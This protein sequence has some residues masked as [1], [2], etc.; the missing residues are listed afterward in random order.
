MQSVFLEITKP[1]LALFIKYEFWFHYLN[2]LEKRSIP[3]YLVSG[4]FRT[5]QHFFKGY[6]GWFKGM[7]NKFEHL[8]VQ[9]ESSLKLLESIGVSNASIS[10]DTRFDSVYAIAQSEGEVPFIEGFK[11]ESQLLICGSTWPEDEKLVLPLINKNHHKLKYIIAPHDVSDHRI[12]EL[13]EKIQL[14]TVRYSAMDETTANSAKV[15]IIDSIGLLAQ[16]YRYG[17][18]AYVGG[19]FGSGLHNILEPAA[20]AMPVLYGTPDSKFYEAYELAKKG[21]GFFVSNADELKKRIDFLLRDELILKM[22][23][24]VSRNYVIESKG[25]VDKVMSKLQT[26]LS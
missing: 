7:L 3:A 2:E 16:L 26:A 24:E 14:T 23:A 10:G 18:I 8:F 5:E 9:N 22:A 15:V 4:S 21:G 1:K 12:K 25:A 17:D 13:E 20:F 19:A 6:G 11:G